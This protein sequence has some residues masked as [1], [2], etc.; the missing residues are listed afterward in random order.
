M[1][2]Q[3]RW[4][5]LLLL[6]WNTG[7]RAHILIQRH[8]GAREPSAVAG[9][10][11]KYARPGFLGSFNSSAV[12]RGPRDSLRCPTTAQQITKGLLG[13][14]GCEGPSL[15]KDEAE[16]SPDLGDLHGDLVTLKRP[17]AQASVPR[18]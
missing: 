7:G 3:G 8:V 18:L 10:S 16:I 5:F 6:V 4:A 15:A 11:G 12:W 1:G 2:A 13:A 9:R 17:Q 14:S